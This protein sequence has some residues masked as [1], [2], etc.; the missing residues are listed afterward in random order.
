MNIENVFSKDNN[1][2]NNAIN[3][4]NG[5]KAFSF[6]LELPKTESFFK[7]LQQI[8]HHETSQ[9][10]DNRE[11]SPDETIDNTANK[12]DESVEKSQDKPKAELKKLLQRL[13]TEDQ[14]PCKLTDIDKA[15]F[16]IYVQD[17]S[18]KNSEFRLDLDSLNENDI[19]F[20]KE[21]VDNPDMVLNTI[22]T[23]NH[24]VN[25]SMVD[26]SGQVSYKSPDFSKGLAN[27]IEYAYKTQRP[28]RLDF[29]GNSS[30]ILRIDTR[31]KLSAEFMSSD[32]A[33]ESILKNSIPNLRNRLDSEGIPYK[34]ILYKENSEKQNKKRRDKGE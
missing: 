17:L 27:L 16:L 32:K 30:V 12:S 22:N 6:E 23:A 7:C 1:V 4:L 2:S 13:A 11:Q 14:V 29:E 20:L 5:V 21:C 10:Q 18:N 15:R 28:V 34:E 26:Q 8:K 24:Q 31:G 9:K 33:M 3:N 19:K 25:F